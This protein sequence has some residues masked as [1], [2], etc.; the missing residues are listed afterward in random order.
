M[1]HIRP[2]EEGDTARLLAI[3]KLC[4]HG[5]EQCAVGVDKKSSV[6]A[7]YALYDNW[8]VLVA[9]ADD[10]AEAEAGEGE[11]GG[12]IGWTVKH[13]PT[14]QEPYVY[15]AEVMV[16][17]DF[18]RKGVA[19]S[20]VNEAEQ[21]A[22]ETGASHLY[23]YIYGPNDASKALFE[24]LGYSSMR[25]LKSCALTAYKK[26]TIA[27]EQYTIERVTTRDIP[28]VVRLINDYYAGYA[29]FAPYT[30]EGFASYLTGITGYGL[31]Q[32]WV[33]REQEADGGNVVA[34]AGLWDWSALAEMCYTNEP[35]LW[36]V[37]RA[38]Y[39]FLSLFGR[40]PRIP[41]EGEFFRVYFMTDYAFEPDHAAAMSAL[42]N[43]LNNV[44]LDAN[45]DFFVANL[46]PDDPLLD[47]LKKFKPQID[48]WQIYAKA[49][50]PEGELELPAFSPFY[51]DIRDCIL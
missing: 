45:R 19:T 5:N 23:C 21:C 13:S 25:T 32:F 42:I 47:V 11:V 29:H 27:E 26:A 44:V 15:L 6:T 48:T 18:R 9:E 38:L 30:P 4:P 7:R 3:E 37:M 2:F 31:E 16:H 14:Q 33:A 35:R 36:K 50:G 10:E 34:C 43:A 49:L 20:L 28:A 46:D 51:V 40:M 17:P 1:V 8:N 24:R 41:A 39:G 12:W 22:H